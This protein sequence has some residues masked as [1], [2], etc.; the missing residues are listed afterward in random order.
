MVQAI[1]FYIVRRLFTEMQACLGW[2]VKQ[3]AWVQEILLSTPSRVKDVQVT[4]GIFKA[5]AMLALNLP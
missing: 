3:T 2:I 5:M 1:Y 4:G